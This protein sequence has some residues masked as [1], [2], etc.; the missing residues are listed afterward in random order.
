MTKVSQKVNEQRLNDV[1]NL[2]RDELRAKSDRDD[3]SSH[4]ISRLEQRMRKRMSFRR[5]GLKEA[6]VSSF[7]ELNSKLES[8]V[9]KLDPELE[10]NAKYYLT[11]MLERY[12]T[13]KDPTNIQ[14]P[15]D[16][17]FLFEFWRFG[18]G[19][20]YGVYGTH[21][22]EKI[23]QEMTVTSSCVPLAL[24]LRKLS[25]YFLAIDSQRR[26]LGLIEVSGSRLTTVP[27]NEDTERTIAIEPSGNMC[28]QLAAGRYLEN[29]LRYIGCDI[30]CQQPKNK[31]MAQR[32]SIDGSLATIDLKSA[33][34][35][36]TPDLVRR[37]LPKKWFDLLMTLRSPEIELSKG[38]RVKLNMISTMGNGF[39]FPLM[40]LIISALIYGFRSLRKGPNLFLD[41]SNTCV[42]GDDIIVP[43]DDYVG[44][45]EVLEQAGFTV[46]HDKS[47]HDGPFRES[48]GGDYYLG[49][50]ITPFY[51]KSL[52]N[53]PAIYV[54]INQVL[55]WAA[56]HNCFVYQTLF[57][58]KSYLNGGLHL[59]PEWLDPSQGVLTAHGPRKYKYLK[60]SAR[61][62]RIREDHPFLCMLAIGGYVYSVGPD[63]FYTPRPFKNEE[64]VR[65]ARIPSGFL[66]GSDPISRTRSITD[67]VSLYVD[68]LK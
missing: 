48:C 33:S 1:A 3:L 6:A 19:A 58:L 4:A 39:T 62:W 57:L 12:T 28:L 67:T 21:T 53:D 61:S 31:L 23:S 10:N 25:P 35:S 46:N 13:A 22:A 20:S 41:W 32:G 16:L 65:K 64:R 55:V 51:I 52:N 60:S 50:D 43:T 8:F 59:V 49:H 42:F 36:I 47:F 66:D 40:T 45:T 18:P 38:N 24:R 30:T 9:V 56:R 44:L 34:D 27:K 63:V 14:N 7:L 68:F 17:S 11:V 29:V 2:L 54:A 26:N 5:P 15:L 37:L